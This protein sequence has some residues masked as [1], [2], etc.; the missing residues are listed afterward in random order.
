MVKIVIK[1]RFYDEISVI[2]F[3]FANDKIFNKC[4]E[5]TRTEGFWTVYNIHNLSE[6]NNICVLS[7]EYGVIPYFSEWITIE[8][9]RFKGWDLNMRGAGFDR[10][11]FKIRLYRPFPNGIQKIV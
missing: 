4:L 7:R 2:S 11:S 3:A 1:S 8:N 5:E 6:I 10:G 9:G